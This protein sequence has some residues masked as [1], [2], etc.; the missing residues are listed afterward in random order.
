MNPVRTQVARYLQEQSPLHQ[1][2]PHNHSGSNAPIY[3]DVFKQKHCTP[4]CIL[5]AKQIKVKCLI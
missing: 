5:L 2:Q 3:F 1:T 4:K